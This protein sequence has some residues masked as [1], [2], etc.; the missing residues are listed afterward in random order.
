MKIVTPPGPKS[1][2]QVA[3]KTK[4]SDLKAKPKKDKS[5]TIKKRTKSVTQPI[6]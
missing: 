4:P 5:Q 1:S 6:R 3:I 2:K